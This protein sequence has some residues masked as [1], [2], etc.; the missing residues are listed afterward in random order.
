MLKLYYAPKTRAARCRWML[1]E[2]GVKYEL[3]RINFQERQH[4]SPEYLKVHPHGMLPA[5]SFDGGMMYESLA[6]N[7][8]LA[9]QYPEKNLAPSPRSPDRAA[10]YQWMVYSIAT[11]ENCIIQYIL[12]S[13]S[14]WR[15][16]H[17]NDASLAEEHRKFFLSVVENIDHALWGKNYILGSEF[18][19]ADIMIGGS[20]M[21]AS[22][23]KLPVEGHSQIP[24][25]IARLQ[26]RPRSPRILDFRASRQ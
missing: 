10:Y 22:M 18:S 7:M 6:I 11:L 16:P 13:P 4:K 23:M 1:E 8:F 25:Y 26:N 14:P 20:L 2:L 15:A 9:D 12:A 24:G 3:Q 5:L 19:V 17:Q 21:F